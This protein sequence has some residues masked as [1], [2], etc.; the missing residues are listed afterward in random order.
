MS[1]ITPA[2]ASAERPP[3]QIVPG[4]NAGE[5]RNAQLDV[6]RQ[7]SPRPALAELRKAAGCANTLAA[8]AVAIERVLKPIDEGTR[9]GEVPKMTDTLIV[10]NVRMPPAI[11]VKFTSPVEHVSDD[12][13]QV[14]DCEEDID[15][16]RAADL[17]VG[18]GGLRYRTVTARA[19]YPRTK[20]KSD[21]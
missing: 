10:V 17:D 7:P 4:H 16:T 11:R 18:S 19:M 20:S 14:K 13:F 3:L 21:V 1:K 6:S 2:N 9:E 5:K 15:P 8:V 12:A